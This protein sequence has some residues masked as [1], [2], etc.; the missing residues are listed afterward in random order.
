MMNEHYLEYLALNS[1]LQDYLIAAALTF[2]SKDNYG[3]Y[4]NGMKFKIDLDKLKDRIT[5]L[6]KRFLKDYVI[7]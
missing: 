3:W 6:Q 4:A 1:I 5:E 2:N 7:S